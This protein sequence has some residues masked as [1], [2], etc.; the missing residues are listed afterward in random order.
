M[1]VNTRQR[2]LSAIFTLVILILG[3]LIYRNFANREP[4][5]YANLS[6]K[7][8]RNVETENFN[9]TSTNV[10]IDIDGR[11]RSIDQVDLNAEVS[12]KLIPMKKRFKEGV[13]YKKGELI[14]N[15]DDTDAKY[16]LLALRSNLLTSITQMMP[17][18]KF[19]YPEA[20]QRW[21]SYLDTYD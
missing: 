16:T 21:K 1:Q 4:V 11:L 13:F 8:I 6:K 14:F 19:D 18:L 9:L 10:I 17:Y 5:S 15:I 12:G 20:F 2:I 3:M 7:D